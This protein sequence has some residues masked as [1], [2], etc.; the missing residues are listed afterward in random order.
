MISVPAGRTPDRQAAER[1]PG[2]PG[3]WVFILGDMTVFGLLF[4]TYAFYR[5]EDPLLYARSQA[6]LEQGWA[7][8]NTVLLLTSSW[9]VALAVDAARQESARRA[10]RLLWLAFA[11]GLGFA[12]IKLGEYR[13]YLAAGAT[14]LADEFWSFYYVL[15]GLH[16][17]HVAVGLALLGLL[18]A[19]AEQGF[20]GGR[21]VML[22]CGA[23][24]WHMVDLLW[25]LLFPLL[26]LLR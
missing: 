26:Y 6:V 24:Y 11:C 9:F 17:M 14:P 4:C 7:G 3:L 25:V 8:F 10:R 12:A 16:L 13:G 21:A 19:R 1:I 2:E 20:G 5:G 18:A 15:T 22:E 23:C